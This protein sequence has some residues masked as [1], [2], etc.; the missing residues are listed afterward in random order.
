MNLFQSNVASLVPNADSS[1]CSL[2]SE[3]IITEGLSKIRRLYQ[4]MN[5][6]EKEPVCIFFG[7]F[8][9]SS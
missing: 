2:T 5:G 3:E 8:Y 1:Q 9:K 4:E 7:L 6:P